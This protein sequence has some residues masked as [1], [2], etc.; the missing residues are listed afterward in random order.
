MRLS[1]VDEEACRGATVAVWRAVQVSRVQV[2]VRVLHTRW[3]QARFGLCLLERGFAL[4]GNGRYVR[5]R[6]KKRH[7]TYVEY[8]KA[9][10]V[11]WGAAVVQHASDVAFWP[12]GRIRRTHAGK[13]GGRRS[14]WWLFAPLHWAKDG[15][16]LCRLDVLQQHPEAKRQSGL[17]HNQRTRPYPRR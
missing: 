6:K 11:V 3:A 15:R 8:W 14:Y 1:H 7:T 9:A 5:Q 10:C 13:V 17:G 4:M 12:H 2:R 16:V